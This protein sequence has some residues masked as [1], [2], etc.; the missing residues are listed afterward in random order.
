MRE[1][2]EA[3]AMEVEA[4]IAFSGKVTRKGL[5]PRAGRVT[6]MEE[7]CEEC[8]VT[9]MTGVGLGEA[10]VVGAGITVAGVFEE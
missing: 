1:S 7:G 2:S 10:G 6:R 9:P 5:S 8:G 4:E 3:M